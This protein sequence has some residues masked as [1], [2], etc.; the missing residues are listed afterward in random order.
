MGVIYNYGAAPAYVKIATQ[1]ASGVSSLTFSNIPQG[2]TDLVIVSSVNSNRGSGLDSL[3]IRFNGDTGNN[4]SVI[5]M[6]SNSSSGITSSRATNQSNIWVGNIT[7]NSTA[8]NFSSNLINIMNYSSNNTYK[9]ILARGGSITTVTDVEANVG[10]WRSTSPI[11]SVT[12]RSETGSNFNSGSTFTIYGIEAALTPKA[13]GGDIIVQDGQYWYHAFRTTGVFVPRQS[14]T[15]DILRI[16]GGGGGGYNLAGGGGAGGVV[17]SSSQ[18]L[19]P[20]TYTATV[21]AGGTGS[22]ASGVIGGIGSQ[23]TLT[24]GSLSLSTVFPGG[25]GKGDYGAAYASASTVAS[26]GG[27]TGAGSFAG[28][29]TTTGQGNAGGRNGNVAYNAGGGGGA[30]AVGSNGDDSTSGIG[31]NGGAGINT[32]ATWAYATGTGVSGYFAGGGGGGGMKTATGTTGAVGGTGGAGGGGN[33][34]S[35]NGTTGGNFVLAAFGTPNTGSGGGG[36]A[37]DQYSVVHAYG[38]AGGS[39]LVIVRYSI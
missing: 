9:T 21:G 10:M 35:D 16:S 33:G 18:S 31:G 32:Y 37:W 24:G 36:G 19:T 28:G 5:Y 29:T 6:Q 2:Y 20:V 12:I 3:A 15:A 8:N 11:T 25:G 39:G 7:A 14:L 1:S 13:S 34:G 26:A 17:L 22:T 4:Y 38:A 27:A 23:T 30:G